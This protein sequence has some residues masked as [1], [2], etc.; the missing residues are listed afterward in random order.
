MSND[1]TDG[2]GNISPSSDGKMMASFRIDR[3]LWAKFQE[4]A[5]TERLTA[6]DVLTEYIQ[7]C[8]EHNRTFYGSSH[9]DIIL[10]PTDSV[11]IDKDEVLKLIDERISTIVSI[12]KDDV[13]TIIDSR[14]QDIKKP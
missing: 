6:T 7:R 14:I 10:T 9:T 1:L 2:S 12:S 11:S 3:E 5:K 4:L 8:T 13:E